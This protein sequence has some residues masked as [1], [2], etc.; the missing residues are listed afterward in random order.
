MAE[1]PLLIFPQAKI[2][3]PPKGRPGFSTPNVP[4][5]QTQISRLTPQFETLEKQFLHSVVTR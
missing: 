4:A 2:V 5:K 1:L 3:D